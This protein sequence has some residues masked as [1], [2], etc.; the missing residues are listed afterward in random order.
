MA[1]QVGDP[2]AVLDIGLATWHRL[3]VLRIDQDDLEAAFQDVEDRPPIHAGRLA[4]VRAVRLH[5][6]LRQVSLLSPQNRPDTFQRSRLARFPLCR[7]LLACNL[8]VCNSSWHCS[9]STIVLRR[10]WI[11]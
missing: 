5:V 11:I 6:L 4:R 7:R 8:P 3:D 10:R 9:Q 2:G 1:Q